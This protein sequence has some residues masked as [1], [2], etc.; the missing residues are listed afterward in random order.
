MLFELGDII[1]LN[2]NITTNRYPRG[3]MGI[4]DIKHIFANNL[5]G[6]I[7]A[8]ELP[9][10]LN[11]GQFLYTIKIFENLYAIEVKQNQLSHNPTSL[12]GIYGFT[13]PNKLYNLTTSSNINGLTK[14]GVIFDND[15]NIKLN[16]LSTLEQLN[17]LNKLN[18]VNNQ[19]STINNINNNLNTSPKVQKTISKYIYYKLVDEWIYKKLF[20]ILAFVKIVNNKPQLIKSMDEY[21]INKLASETDEEIELRADY[22]ESNIIS[23]KLVSK[24]LKKTVNR[25]CL[26]W[27]ELD[28][29]EKIIQN[30]FLEYLKDLLEESI[31]RL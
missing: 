28:K 25:M 18:W 9:N 3:D 26:N 27:Y 17:E 15:P 2:G 4:N 21:D 8:V 6:T 10:F 29:H 31:R 24:V 11:G 19:I 22:L 13:S 7:F 12:N 16:S 14:P 20:P 23:K 5:K 1:Y 30:V